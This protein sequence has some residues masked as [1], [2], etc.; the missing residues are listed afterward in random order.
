MSVRDEAIADASK[1][2]HFMLGLIEAREWEYVDEQF[3]TCMTW[4][5]DAILKRH[6][7]G[8]SGADHEAIED[9]STAISASDELLEGLLIKGKVPIPILKDAV[10]VIETAARVAKAIRADSTSPFLNPDEEARP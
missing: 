5:A 6:Q 3:A 9:A 2:L 7:V 10:M 8:T 4:M 1:F